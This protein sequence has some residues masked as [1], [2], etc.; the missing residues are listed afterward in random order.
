MGL[1]SSSAAREEEVHHRFA[2]DVYGAGR[3]IRIADA[4]IEDAFAAGETVTLEA[5]IRETAHA[6]GRWVRIQGAVGRD[7]YAAGYSVD[8][9]SAVTGDVTAAGYRVEIARSGSVGEDV[10]LAGQSV[11]VRGAVAGDATLMGNVVEIAAPITG[12]VEV[13]ASQLRF[14]DGARINGTLAYRTDNP[15]TIPAG[16][17]PPERVVG[18]V[19]EREAQGPVGIMGWLIGGIVILVITLLFAALFGFV[20]PHMLQRT[21]ETLAARPWRTLGLGLVATSALFGSLLVLAVSLIGIPL[22]PLI[23]LAIPIALVAGYLTTAHAI[24]T[25]LAR[26]LRESASGPAAF[27]AILLGLLVLWAV[28]LVPLLGWI[29][30]VAAVVFGVGAWFS[31]AVTPRQPASMTA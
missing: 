27:G 26:R 3:D 11:L 21:R 10:L 19:V 24:G 29:V 5:A 1:A 30:A 31:L 28:G 25:G 17:I 8:V 23:I 2:G 4:D 12:S 20:F 15:V 18:E 7:V 9:T 14:A 16:V 13:R 22:V 6:A